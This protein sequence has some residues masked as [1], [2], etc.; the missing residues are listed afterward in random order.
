MIGT[1]SIGHA[2]LNDDSINPDK[3]AKLIEHTIEKQGHKC[4]CCGIVAKKKIR[5]ITSNRN[6]SISKD[7]VVAVC[8]PCFALHNGG[9]S[10]DGE[11]IGSMI[12]LP[13]ISQVELIKLWYVASYY[14]YFDT[15]VKKSNANS[16]LNELGSLS[17]AIIRL[18]G[19]DNPVYFANILRSFKDSAYEKRLVAFGGFRWLPNWSHEIFKETLS[20]YNLAGSFLNDEFVAE[21]TD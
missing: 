17:E 6:E 3:L 20:T 12:L 11:R 21:L 8:P 10:I 2:I 1:F 9:M 16:Y 18:N 5:L 15:G 4:G 19:T 13:Q 14:R 7:N